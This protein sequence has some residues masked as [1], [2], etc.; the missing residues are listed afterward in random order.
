MKTSEARKGEKGIGDYRAPR[1]VLDLCSR[2]ELMLKGRKGRGGGPV[3]RNDVVVA[4]AA[5]Q[6]SLRPCLLGRC[7]LC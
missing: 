7:P 1:V 3:V 2:L 4:V 6:R 5:S